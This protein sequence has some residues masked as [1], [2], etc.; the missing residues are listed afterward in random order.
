MSRLPIVTFLY[1]QIAINL[2]H[3]NISSL[4]Y[5]SFQA[6]GNITE[7]D[8]SHNQLSTVKSFVFEECDCTVFKLNHNLISNLSNI[9]IFANL[10]GLR[11]LNLSHNFITE[12]N[13]KH[14]T[15]KKLYELDTIDLS[16]NNISEL[17]GSVFEKFLSVRLINLTHNSLRKIGKCQV[18][19]I[20]RRCEVRYWQF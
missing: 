9:D 3:N 15:T 16:Y 20:I 7:L 4:E 17:S 8:L 5:K 2:S 1:Q 13:R 6:L 10:T 19:F 18:F 14:F 11:M 12:I